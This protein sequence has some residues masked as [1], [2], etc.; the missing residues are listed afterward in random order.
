MNRTSLI[1]AA[2]ICGWVAASAAPTTKPE[3]ALDAP[4]PRYPESSLSPGRPAALRSDADLARG[5]TAALLDDP[6][7]P[8]IGGLT[9]GVV[10]G[11]ATLRGVARSQADKDVATAKA[12]A[13]AGLRNVKNLISVEP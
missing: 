6:E 10:N 8:R 12:G 13:V 2:A 5:L 9:I 1:V 4:E 7:A 11:K 3:E